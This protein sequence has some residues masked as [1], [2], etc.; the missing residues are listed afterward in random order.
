MWARSALVGVE[1]FTFAC[2][3]RHIPGNQWLMMVTIKL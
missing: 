2:S 1:Q 3:S